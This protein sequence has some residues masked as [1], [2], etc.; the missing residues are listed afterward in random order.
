[1]LHA[2]MLS[3][4]SRVQLFATLWTVACQAPLFKG[5]SR[6]EYW[7]GWPCPPPED[8]PHS[9]IKP[10]SLTSPALAGRFFTTCAPGKPHML[11]GTAREKQNKPVRSCRH[12][13]VTDWRA[14]INYI[15]INPRIVQ[16][17]VIITKY[18]CQEGNAQVI[19]PTGRDLRQAG[20]GSFSERVTHSR[21]DRTREGSFSSSSGPPHHYKLLS[22]ALNTAFLQS[23]QCPSQTLS[24]SHFTR[25][26]HTSH[27]LLSHTSLSSCHHLSRVTQ[28]L[29]GAP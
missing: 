27:L 8:L 20:H 7:S 19:W 15:Q 14:N 13:G 23:G 26:F 24:T 16:G 1:M 28:E 29:S 9:G 2:C 6:P 3:R 17:P 18:D 4:F 25:H 11:H 21:V 10:T 22:G 12:R 5:F